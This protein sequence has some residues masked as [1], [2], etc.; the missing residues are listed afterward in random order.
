[1]LRDVSHRKLMPGIS[2]SQE[3]DTART[4]LSKHSRLSKSS[5]H[6]PTSSANKKD[7]LTTRRPSMV[8]VIDFDIDRIKALDVIDRVDTLRAYD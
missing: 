6:S 1:M 4:R 8:P 5:N 3:F 2:K 7:L